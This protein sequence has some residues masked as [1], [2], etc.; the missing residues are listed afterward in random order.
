MEPLPAEVG[1]ETRKAWEETDH[2]PLTALSL[3]LA[4]GEAWP[5]LESFWEMPE[6]A[7]LRSKSRSFPSPSIIDVS[8]TF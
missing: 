3:T 6:R 5:F 2:C 1:G 8:L 7:A 4:P